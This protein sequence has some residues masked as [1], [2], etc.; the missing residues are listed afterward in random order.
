MLK[1]L[2]LTI[3]A[4]L[5]FSNL[6]TA[7]DYF[8]STMGDD[9]A[10]GTYDA[11]W[12]T[13]Q[14]A[15]DKAI[16]GSVV[17]IAQGEYKE[18]VIIT[19]SGNEKNGYITFMGDNSGQT[20]IDGADFTVD[21]MK[22]FSRDEFN[23][24]GLDT[25]SG[26]VEII[27]SSYIRLKNLKIRKYV[28]QSAAVFP[29]GL[30]VVKTEKSNTPMTNIEIVNLNICDIK[31]KS[32]SD[33]G[34]QGMA[35]YG[36]NPDAPISSVLIRGCEICNCLLG[37]SESLTLNGNIDGFRIEYNKVHN[38]D[39]IG[40]DCIG[41]EG[42]AGKINTGSDPTE[43]GGH[44]PN[45]RTRNGFIEHNLVYSCSTDAPVKNPTYP[46]NDFSAGGIYVDG[47]KNITIQYNTVYQCDV[48]I[49]ISSEHSGS[50]DTGNE[51][52]TE[53]II[54]R[55]NIVAYCGQYGIGL[56]GYDKKRGFAVQC[57]LANNTI[58][59]CSS[60]G[61]GGGQIF[62]NKSHDN[63]ITG[64]ILVARD[65]EDKDDYDGFN[66]SGDDWKWDH[67]LVLSSGLDSN[68]NYNNLLSA[69]LY[70]TSSGS[71]NI[72]WKW[73]MTDSEDPKIG[74]DS[75]K[76]IDRDALSGNPN[77]IKATNSLYKGTENFAISD[78]ESPAIDN[79]NHSYVK[80]AGNY[81]FIGKTRVFNGI[82]DIGAFELYPEGKAPAHPFPQSIK[83]PYGIKPSNLSQNDMNNAVV[84]LYNAWK[85]NYLTN[86][87]A[88][89]EGH[90]LW[91]V[92]SSVKFK[93][94]T[95]SEAQ[96]YGM[97]I[98]TLMAGYDPDA[99]KIFNGL[100]FF[101][102]KYKNSHN[103]MKWIV[104]DNGN[105]PESD[106][107]TDGDMDIAMAL[108]MADKQWGSNGSIN[109][110]EQ[111]KELIKAIMKWN[112]DSPDD[113][114]G[115]EETNS[116]R[117]T[118]GDAW[119]AGDGT[120]ITDK[121]TRVSD[122]MTGHLKVFSEITA[123]SDWINV[124]D[125]CFALIESI[126]KNFSSKGLL[127][128]FINDADESPAP[129]DSIET[130]YDGDYYYN[131]CRIPWRLVADYL[132]SGDKRA[133]DTVN[134][135]VDFMK[136]TSN[137]NPDNICDGYKLDGTTIGDNW[138]E[139][140]ASCAFLAPLAVGGM[141]DPKYQTWLNNS[142]DFIRSNNP[143]QGYYEDTIRILCSLVITGNY[144]TPTTIK[145]ASPQTEISILSAPPEAVPAEIPDASLKASL[146]LGTDFGVLPND[147]QELVRIF[148]I[149]NLGS[150]DLNIQ[151]ISFSGKG[152]SFF[153]IKTPADTILKPN[154][155][156]GFSIAFRPET[157]VGI[158]DAVVTI[159]N[160]DSDENPYSFAIKATSLPGGE[161]YSLKYSAD[162][163]GKIIGN[164][165]QSLNSGLDGTPVAAIPDSH[166]KFNA[167][168]DGKIENPRVDRNVND[169]LSVTASFVKKTQVSITY[170]N[171]TGPNSPLENDTIQ[172]SAIPPSANS[173]F[174]KW[175]SNSN[176]IFANPTKMKTEYSVPNENS[177]LEAIFETV[178]TLEYSSGNN[179]SLIGETLQSVKK[180]ESASPVTAVPNTGFHFLKWSDNI[181][182]N[183]RTDS[184]LNSNISVN[185]EFEQNSVYSL[186][187]NNG[188]GSGDYEQASII[189]IQADSPPAGSHFVK[190]ESSSSNSSFDD[191]TNTSTQFTMPPEDCN[192]NPLFSTDFILEYSASPGGTL[193]GTTK[194]SVPPGTNGSPVE[195][196]PETSFHFLKWS[197]NIFDNPRTDTSLANDIFSTAIFQENILTLSPNSNSIN[198]NGGS[199]IFSLTSNIEL[200]NDLTVN[201]TSS[202]DNKITIPA[203]VVIPAG[204]STV[205]F[206]AVSKDNSIADGNVNVKIIA[207]V[208]DFKETQAF[209]EI[210]DDEIPA[211]VV[212]PKKITISENKGSA[213][214]L[215]VLTT[216]P[217]QK[218]I[219]NISNNNSTALTLYPD[220]L[221]FDSSNWNSP[222]TILIMAI[223]NSK[224]G[225]AEAVIKTAV[226]SLN[227]DTAFSNLPSQ[228]VHIS[229]L[230]DEPVLNDDTAEINISETTVIN[231][232]ENDEL[233]PGEI[234]TVS[235]ITVPPPEGK[236]IISDSGSTITYTAGNS[237][238]EV[239]F[240]YEATSSLG[241]NATAEVKVT[242][243]QGNVVAQGMLFTIKASDV[244][245]PSG[246]KLDLF[247][248]FPKVTVSYT[249]IMTNKIKSFKAKVI[250]D[251]P[252]H[253]VEHIECEFKKSAYLYNKKLLKT[254]NK[255]GQY[256]S[257]WL[258]INPL[259]RMSCD[260][261]MLFY[262]ENE[263]MDFNG[264]I[265]RNLFLVPPI[266]SSI[267]KPE[268]VPIDQHKKLSLNDE[269]TLKGLFFGAKKPKL[270]LEYKDPVK[271]S[272]KRI[273]LK[274]NK[275][276]PFPNAKGKENKSCMNVDT[277][278]SKIN[279]FM[280]KKWWKNYQPGK[281]YIL[282][283]NKTGLDTIPINTE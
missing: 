224:H 158:F 145:T 218:V 199:T 194:Q 196:I 222:Q 232:L 33:G 263:D 189:D 140:S 78:P 26:L 170:I 268:G 49:E 82:Q 144:W 163:H 4:S 221:V 195:A 143:K 32:V 174:I 227:S 228:N 84:Q 118:V 57:E 146:S 139:N 209:L 60:L 31:N 147:K 9:T 92:K 153:R 271:N 172:I 130:P 240:T 135:I 178:Y 171:G 88:D 64:N 122:F 71:E 203:T 86:D 210:L 94:D 109:Y 58:Y 252:N 73:E 104:K 255:S 18:R 233:R 266:I 217:A 120:D 249:D 179:G 83:Y 56:G 192:V 248:D 79:G 42:T 155:S 105:T 276:L 161:V 165:N 168:S 204:S 180:D 102:K 100:F 186:T 87:F 280:P 14:H 16:P 156:T 48:G 128:D 22:N 256:T 283:D 270:Y 265:A 12:K 1:K 119:A 244:T 133:F 223:D 211:F 72:R 47:G 25:A 40:I 175:K 76:Q 21:D 225:D 121:L 157:T 241:G 50:D 3:I 99:K 127:P 185:A 70:H 216:Q 219:F 126:T 212:T 5:F 115:I 112:V 182:D 231:V 124:S 108:I 272:V 36:G 282:I 90:T 177:T 61:W 43:V 96:G 134:K 17:H 267:E 206:S 200:L 65:L 154:K 253:G 35:F 243:N 125:R 279:F 114:F 74:F 101:F 237:P 59:K 29:M 214:I 34:A 173:I 111:A 152:A 220:T 37:Q 207:N 181:T 52:N 77:F 97:L 80:S 150:A 30:M 141:I 242:V 264:Q 28:C 164:N 187:V 55:N 247:R 234:L 281:Y 66:N 151:S 205:N 98:T 273:K 63:L 213:G 208:S 123:N 7:N 236:A 23:L 275:F 142:F 190:W 246:G 68:Y 269:I 230:D 106:N 85:A 113:N 159:A 62:I 215:L 226:E 44:N 278:E 235:A 197:D 11:P 277:G 2:F 258:Q 45:D 38:N 201:L 166:Y 198:E 81:D 250:S 138:G 131:S 67:G 260:L 15:A 10:T 89:W 13:I 254:A 53:N 91:R 167:W 191:F 188:T 19:K 262:L 202:N 51:R 162:D 229:I 75:L 169:N 257:E 238:G 117:L 69:N 95:V 46:K 137:N 54:C 160:N 148:Q 259:K 176:G 24:Y 93:D 193:N 20:I 8:V 274:I 261:F 129:P 110:I 107:A 183:P 27:D 132:Y 149:N 184:K 6:S 41:W 136:K 116:W 245:K 39:N 103:L 239:T 251:V